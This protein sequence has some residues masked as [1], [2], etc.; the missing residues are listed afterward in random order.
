MLILDHVD[1]AALADP[2]AKFAAVTIVAAVAVVIAL[3]TFFEIPL[4]L[5]LVQAGAPLGAVAALLFAGPAVNLPSLFTLARAG[6]P[7]V[8]LALGIAV[9][10]VA[11]AGGML[12]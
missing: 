6:S 8:A 11:V 12:L 1:L 9:F 7:R 3:P 5:L 10:V 4:A 2:G